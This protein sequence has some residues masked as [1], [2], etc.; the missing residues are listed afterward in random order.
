MDIIEHDNID[1]DIIKINKNSLLLRIIH[2]KVY[3]TS[4]TATPTFLG[5]SI[6]LLVPGFLAESYKTIGPVP[7]ETVRI[8]LIVLG[9]VALTL[10]IFFFFQ[11]LRLRDTHDPKNIIESMM[12]QGS[13]NQK[14]LKKD[15]KFPSKPRRSSLP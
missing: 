11:W 3:Y 10:T 9:V 7:G 13:E 2:C 8:I 1:R 5:I 12:Y 14:K 15:I 6:S 4:L